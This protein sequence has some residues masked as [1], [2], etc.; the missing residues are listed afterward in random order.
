[1]VV[2]FAKLLKVIKNKNFEK[3]LKGRIWQIFKYYL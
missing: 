3:I 2:P 1:M